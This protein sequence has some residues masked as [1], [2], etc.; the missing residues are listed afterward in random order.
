MHSSLQREH[1]IILIALS[2]KQFII[3]MG[4]CFLSCDSIMTPLAKI[5]QVNSLILYILGWGPAGATNVLDPVT[6]TLC[7]AWR[8]DQSCQLVPKIMDTSLQ[9]T[10]LTCIEMTVTG[11]QAE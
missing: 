8:K 5:P 2:F 3:W 6:E 4:I 7:I 10:V 9:L 11:D 1:W